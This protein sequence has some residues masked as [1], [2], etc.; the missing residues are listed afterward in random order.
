MR[1]DGNYEQGIK[2]FDR[3]YPDERGK[4]YRV[5]FSTSYA[6]NSETPTLIHKHY[7]YAKL[8]FVLREPASR[9][10]SHYFQFLKTGAELPPISEIISG[11]D[12]LSEIVFSYSDYRK[13]YDTYSN[14]FSREQICL[15]S[16]DDLIN[17]PEK[18]DRQICDFLDLEDF[19]YRP[20]N[21][22]KNKASSAKNKIINSLLVGPHIRFLSRFAWIFGR[23]GLLEVR[24]KI[25][26]WNRKDV[27]NPELSEQDLRLLQERLAPQIEM[28]ENLKRN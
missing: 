12:K 8:F 25:V 24:R 6:V 10:V 4:E 23:L 20:A 26:R 21:S 14:V 19:E 7:P 18:I 17:A 3:Q 16:F 15:L 11:K 5:D 22:E 28:Y 13:I 1:P 27:K 9:F 2:W